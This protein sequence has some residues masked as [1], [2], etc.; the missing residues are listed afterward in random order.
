MRGNKRLKC[1][2]ALVAAPDSFIKSLTGKE[3]AAHAVD[4]AQVFAKYLYPA[5]VK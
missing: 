2:R 3:Y 4:G 5:L 1:I